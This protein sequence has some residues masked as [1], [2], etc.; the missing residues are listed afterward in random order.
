MSDEQRLIQQSQNGDPDAFCQLARQYERRVFALALHYCGNPHDAEDLS[1]EVWLKAFRAIGTFRGES[2]FYTWVRQITINTFLNRQRE[3]VVTKGEERMAVKLDDLAVLDE[4]DGS[5]D[6]FGKNFENTLHQKMLV[7]RVFAGLSELTPQQRLIFLLKHREGLTCE[8][9]SRSC[10][11]S[12]GTVK[13]SLFRTVHRL[14]DFLGIGD[15]ERS[16][17]ARLREDTRTTR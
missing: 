9:I 11:V 15:S 12:P 2:G 5:T 3:T 14:R 4:T 17:H 1:Q 8:E 13:K 6:G 16:G 10:E 7:E